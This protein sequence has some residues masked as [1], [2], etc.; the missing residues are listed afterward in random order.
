MENVKCNC[1][2]MLHPLSIKVRD[3][4]MSSSFISSVKR[5]SFKKEEG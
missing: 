2:V 5:E 4:Q 1:G 3:A